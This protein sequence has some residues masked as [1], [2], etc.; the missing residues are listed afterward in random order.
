M[1]RITIQKKI[2]RMMRNSYLSN[3]N[4]SILL[5]QDKEAFNLLKEAAKDKIFFY[6]DTIADKNETL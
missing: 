5:E 2:L 6:F 4:N 1:L 3:I